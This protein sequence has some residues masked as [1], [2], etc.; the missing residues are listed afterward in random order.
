MVVAFAMCV[1]K[2]QRQT[3]ECNMNHIP[4]HLWQIVTWSFAGMGAATG[5]AGFAD[6]LRVPDTNGGSWLI[7]GVASVIAWALAGGSLWLQSRRSLTERRLHAAL[8]A[9]A[10]REIARAERARSRAM[11]HP[12]AFNSNGT[13]HRE[14]Y[15]PKI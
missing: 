10:G 5:L 15:Q 14:P 1:K 6:W 12:A 13:S 9:Y 3:G 11:S 4:T 2:Q 7:L 8:D